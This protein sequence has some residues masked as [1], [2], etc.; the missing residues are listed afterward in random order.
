MT[1]DQVSTR[2]PFSPTVPLACCCCCLLLLSW[3][4]R[5]KAARAAEHFLPRCPA[6]LLLSLLSGT[7]R[8]ACCCPT[9]PGLLWELVCWRRSTIPSLDNFWTIGGQPTLE[10]PDLRDYLGRRLFFLLPSILFFFETEEGNYS[11]VL[12]TG[13]LWDIHQV[14]PNQFPEVSLLATLLLHINGSMPPLGFSSP[15]LRTATYYV[16]QTFCYSVKYVPL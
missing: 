9:I 11:L 13:S 14:K 7:K 4:K 16:K 8:L 10:P 2:R 15:F 3:R 1:E 6:G 12:L 5:T